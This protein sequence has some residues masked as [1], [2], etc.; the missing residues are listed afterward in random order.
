[1]AKE[2]ACTKKALEQRVENLTT[3]QQREVLHTMVLCMQTSNHVEE[4]L[5][6]QTSIPTCTCKILQEMVW[7]CKHMVAWDANNFTWHF[8]DCG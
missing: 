2:E 4:Y 5:V 7:P 3:F 1:M 8:H 6:D